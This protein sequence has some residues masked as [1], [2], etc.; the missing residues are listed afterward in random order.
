MKVMSLF[1]YLES[2]LDQPREVVLDLSTLLTST[3]CREQAKGRLRKVLASVGG[4]P[5]GKAYTAVDVIVDHARSGDEA[6]FAPPESP[7]AGGALST[8]LHLP[9]KEVTNTRSNNDQALEFYRRGAFS[10]AQALWRR[11]LLLDSDRVAPTWNLALACWRLGETSSSEL[12]ASLETALTHGDIN[13]HDQH[14]M[15]VAVLSEGHHTVASGDDESGPRNG[16]GG[17][18]NI[19]C[20]D[21]ALPLM[22]THFT[23]S[24]C[25]HRLSMG[26]GAVV[27]LSS[28]SGL[29]YKPTA[30]LQYHGGP[31]C[32]YLWDAVRPSH[33]SGDILFSSSTETT[34][35]ASLAP[36]DGIELLALG[37]AA[38]SAYGGRGQR[39]PSLLRVT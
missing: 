31:I 7:C 1:E 19:S 15:V 17:R 13:A 23:C 25:G 34:M 35:A 8:R 28:M 37:S 6:F 39:C 22:Q 38:I 16:I 32:P 4:L 11:A 36:M 10:S 29:H 20:P 21:L 24:P 33:L 26:M 18:E 12:C 5:L 30:A 9:G 27:T 14:E 3:S 2:M